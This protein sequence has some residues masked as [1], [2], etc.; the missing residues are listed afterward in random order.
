MA[1]LSVKAKKREQTGKGATK[2]Y[3][4][5]GWIPAEFY[6]SHDDNVHLLLN[7]K[8]LGSTLV[9]SH[10]LINL[11]VEGQKKKLQCFI[12][13]IQFHPV[14]GNILHVDFQGI[15]KG[16]KITITIPVTLQGTAEGVKNGGILEHFIRELEIECLP[17]DIPDAIEID[18]SDFVMGD[19][20]RI[21]DLEVENVKIFNDPEELILNIE[22][23]K[24][25][26]EIEEELEGELEEEMQEPEVIGKEEEGEEEG[27]EEES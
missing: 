9:D 8:D 11:N 1:E 23:P 19:S 26:E 12:K 21:K 18:V 16:E 5:E 17:Q 20:F 24:P 15:R 4:Y 14:K 2:K 22:Y 13:D 7:E 3:R 27:E 6:S 10:G 25:E